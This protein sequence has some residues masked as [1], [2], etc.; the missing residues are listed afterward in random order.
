MTSTALNRAF[1]DFEK[2]GGLLRTTADLP[3]LLPS[4]PVAA[5]ATTG[6][7]KT[8]LWTAAAGAVLAAVAAQTWRWWQSPAVASEPQQAEVRLV[9]IALPTPA[10]AGHVLLPATIRPWQTATLNARA[11]GY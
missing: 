9:N 8:M 10:A 7:W 1:A 6:A 3:I 5:R 4:R 2:N 11:S